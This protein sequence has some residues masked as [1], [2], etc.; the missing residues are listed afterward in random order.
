MSIADLTYY[1]GRVGLFA[2]LDALGVGAGDEVITQAYTCVAVPEAILATGAT[3]RFVDIAVDS[4]NVDPVAVAD[5]ITDTTRAI[6]VQ[7]TFGVPADMDAL[8]PL[9]AE[10][11][12]AVIEDC[13]HTLTG[14]LQ[15][16]ALGS[17]G[18]AAFYSFE[19]GKPLVVGV[20]GSVRLN[21]PNLAHRVHQ[22][23]GGYRRP[24]LLRQAKL[25]AQ[26]AGF[27]VVYHP[28]LYWPVRD[29]FRRLSRVGA[30]EGNYNALANGQPDEEFSLRMA[31]MQR[32]M[33]RARL[34]SVRS[35]SKR[36]RHLAAHYRDALGSSAQL[37]AEPSGADTIYARL[38]LRVTDKGRLLDAARAAGIELAQWY[39][40]PV[41]PLEGEAA[42]LAGYR[43][44]SCPHA[45]SRCGDVVS[46]PMHGR[47]SDRFVE[48]AARFL[49]GATA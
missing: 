12:I 25:A 22:A 33:L 47:V 13:C 38:P 23:Y 46:L 17:F 18:V 14:R 20:G 43:A 5:A 39:T 27:G 24:S 30:V 48:R 28:R 26:T 19:W 41:H 37:F 21:D 42:R 15:G 8:M 10:R 29:A 45:E 49:R 2:I 3:P 36:R 31:P 32:L 4:L 1:R 6:V 40:T 34:R 44:G 16:R 35:D 11:G 9:A 7:H